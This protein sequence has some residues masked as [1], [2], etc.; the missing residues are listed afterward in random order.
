MPDCGIFLFDRL[1]CFSMGLSDLFSL[2]S[3]SNDGDGRVDELSKR[4]DSVESRLE[5]LESIAVR[6]S[7]VELLRKEVEELRAETGSAS[8]KEKLRSRILALVDQGLEKVSVKEKIVEQEDLCSES[9]FYENW[10]YLE[11]ASFLKESEGSEGFEILVD[12]S[13]L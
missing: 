4:L 11:D 8:T 1:S 9:Y 7:D 5:E 3:G 13:E 10:N 6:D 12:S 2:L